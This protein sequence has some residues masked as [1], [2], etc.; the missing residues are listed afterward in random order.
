MIQMMFNGRVIVPPAIYGMQ[1]PLPVEE[2]MTAAFGP[3]IHY[4][5]NLLN[6]LRKLG[7]T[8]REYYMRTDGGR[9]SVYP[10]IVVWKIKGEGDV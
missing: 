2:E 4:A 10:Y 8:N 5:A 3:N 6:T 9:G 1:K 7:L